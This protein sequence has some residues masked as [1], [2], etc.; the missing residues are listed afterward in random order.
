[1]K[2]FKWVLAASSL[3]AIGSAAALA[4]G[5]A[6]AAGSSLPTLTLALNGKTVAV[7]GSMV[8]G[9]VNV[10]TTVTGEA[11]GEAILLRLNAG[12]SPSAFLQAA[13]AVGAHR[14][15][16][17][18]ISPFGSIVFDANSP[19]GT[20]SAE[21]VLTPGTYIAVDGG[22]SNGIPPHTSFTVTPSTAPVPLPKSAATVS[23]IE[24]GFT[25]PTTLRDGEL[26]RFI[27]AGFVVHMDDWLKVKNMAAAKLLVK[28][29]L[30]N[31]RS[32][33]KLVIGQGEFAGPMSNGGMLQ[34]TVTEP[35]G[36]YVQ[37][38]FMNAQDGREHTQLGMERIIKIVK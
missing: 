19:K 3:L 26:V 30:A 33:R 10:E 14:G 21:T 34:L 6:G 13:Q 5:S 32:A 27:N 23:S 4:A 9:A 31:N 15:D 35:P 1:M 11:T 28:A 16:L 20:S 25:G 2:R 18:Y 22:G 8:S 7:G 37:A 38:C 24:F 36:I 17:N 12:E 29:L